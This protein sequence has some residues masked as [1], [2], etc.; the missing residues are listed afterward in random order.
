MRGAD[1]Q[2]APFRRL[3]RNTR[4][5]PMGNFEFLR[6]FFDFCERDKWRP[7]HLPKTVATPPSAKLVAEHP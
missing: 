7:F 4:V 3:C 2:L 1:G 6:T 5:V